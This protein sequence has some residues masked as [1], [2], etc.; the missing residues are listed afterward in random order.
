MRSPHLRSGELHCPSLRE[1][2]L[3]RLYGILLSGK[4]VLLHSLFIHSISP[5]LICINR[6]HDCFILWV[7]IQDYF[8]YFVAQIFH[9]LEFFH[10]AP[11][12]FWHSSIIVCVRGWWVGEWMNSSLLS[13]TA[14][15]CKLIWF[16]SCLSPVICHFSKMVRENK[17]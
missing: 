10:L 2:H 16:I 9:H 12:S 11:V 1:E 17:I 8:T 14:K 4:F 3:C 13:G 6:T 15:Y 5:S 7:I